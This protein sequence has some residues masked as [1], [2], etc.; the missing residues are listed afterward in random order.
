M[1]AVLRGTN[2]VVWEVGERRRV[3]SEGEEERR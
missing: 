2:R 3:E 1:I